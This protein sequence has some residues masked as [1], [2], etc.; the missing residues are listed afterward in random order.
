MDGWMDESGLFILP[1]YLPTYTPAS[2][3]SVV[4]AR[5]HFATFFFVAFA[6]AFAFV[7][8]S[9]ALCDIPRR[10]WFHTYLPSPSRA[11]FCLAAVLALP[12][13]LQPH[14]PLQAMVPL[15]YTATWQEYSI[16]SSSPSS[17]EFVAALST[18][19]H[20]RWASFV[21]FFVAPLIR[22]SLDP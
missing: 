2:L 10:P 4:A 21:D 20:A 22:P 18:R 16:I 19:L 9:S 6:F 12:C 3:H 17:V 8:A 1:N 11:S 15:S 5:F 13:L 14:A 7:F